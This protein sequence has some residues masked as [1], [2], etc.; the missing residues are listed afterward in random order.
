MSV[1]IKLNGAGKLGNKARTI[2]LTN[3]DP[4][5]ENSL[6][7][8]DAVVPQKGELP[9]VAPTFT[10]TMASYSLTTLRIPQN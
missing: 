10:C 7:K 5:A 9:G 3:P 4:D 6:D 1:T 8:P 2:T